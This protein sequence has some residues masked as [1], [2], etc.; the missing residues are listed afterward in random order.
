[1][2]T[3]GNRMKTYESVWHTSVPPNSYVVLRLDGRTFHTL[4]RNA[5]RPY[6]QGVASAMTHAAKALCQEISGAEF[7]YLQSDEISILITDVRTVRSQLWFDGDVQKLTSVGASIVSAAFN[8]YVHPSMEVEGLAGINRHGHFDA[9]VLTL[10]HP[11]EVA[12]YFVWRQRD[13][14]RNAVLA[15]AR[16]YFPQADLHRKDIGMVHAM[17]RDEHEVTFPGDYPSEFVNGRI[18]YKT[19]RFSWSVMADR[20]AWKWKAAPQFSARTGNWLAENIPAQPK[21]LHESPDI[22][23]QVDKKEPW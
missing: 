6:D 9:R 14:Q 19:T 5:D 8:D 13:A 23:E 18:L 17:L 20:T 22:N 7:A 1:M 2:S 12:N 4:L 21:W 3:L 16:V 15:A 11:I 10:P